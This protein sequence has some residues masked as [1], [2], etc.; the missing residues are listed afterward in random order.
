MAV[1]LDSPWA[2]ATYEPPAALDIATLETAIVRQ[3]QSQIN[4]IEIAHYPDRPEAYRL[5]H[6]IGA[7]LVRYDGAKYGRQMDIGA[8][9]QTRTLRFA[10]RLL[11][12]D[13]GW[14]YGGEADGTS[15]GAYAL[16]EAIRTALTGFTQA[17]CTET[18]PVEEKFVERDRQGGVWIYEAVYE[19][20]TM[21]MELSSTPNYPLFTQGRALEEGGQTGVMVN[22]AR[23]QF[24][25]SGNIQLPQ[26]NISLAVVAS[27]PPGQ[28]YA[29]GFDYTVDTVNGIISLIPGAK[30]AAGATVG[31]SYV[32][33]EVVTVNAV[34][35][36]APTA[37]SN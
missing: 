3:L 24:D 5:T 36:S 14:N 7:A 26:G 16:L 22:A 10:I 15:P 37:P 32:Y 2:G 18:H 34:G 1:M 8:V 23:Y 35:G 28:V 11:V 17:G 21:A 9:V 20:T 12:R 19:F 6:R 31:V 27:V 13:L 29:N 25:A 4:M 30:I 33:A